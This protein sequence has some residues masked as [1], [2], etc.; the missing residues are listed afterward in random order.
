M[1]HHIA[2]GELLIDLEYEL[3]TLGLW[4]NQVPPEEALASTQPFALDTLTFPQW[5]Q[6]VFIARMQA[7]IEAKLPLPEQCGIAPMSQEYFKESHVSGTRVT[8]IFVS[9]DELLSGKP[10]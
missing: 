2:A 7:L 3:R 6:F 8:A 10:A 1:S 5:I 9:F 4:Q